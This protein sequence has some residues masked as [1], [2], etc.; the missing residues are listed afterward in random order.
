[1]RENENAVMINKVA[2][3]EEIQSCQRTS[4]RQLQ[5]GLRATTWGP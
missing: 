5:V 4:Y 2:F 3:G 1:M